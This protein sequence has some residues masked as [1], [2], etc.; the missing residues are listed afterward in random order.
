MFATIELPEFSLQSI[1]RH[2]SAAEDSSPAVLVDTSG[3]KPLVKQRNQAARAAAIEID[4]SLSQAQARAPQVRFF[5]PSQ[6]AEANASKLLFNLAYAHSPFLEETLPGLWTLDLKGLPGKLQAPTAQTLRQELAAHGLHARIGLAPTPDTALFAARAAPPPDFCLLAQDLAAFRRRNLIHIACPSGKLAHILHQ[7][8]IHTLE[9]LVALPRPAVQ[10]RLGAEGGQIWDQ[11]AGKTTRVLRIQHPPH[12]FEEKIELEYAI[13]NLE[14]L[15]FILRRFLDSLSLQ[16]QTCG[17]AAQALK[18][19]LQQED[20][21]TA[22]YCQRFEL[23]EPTQNADRLFRMLHLHLGQ[24]Q[25]EHAL[26]GVQIELEPVNPPHRQEGLFHTSLRDPWRFHE[27]LTQ[28]TGLLG[29]GHM[30]SPRTVA[31]HKPGSFE[32]VPLPDNIPPLPVNSDAPGPA[33]PLRRFRPPIP[34][35]V[36]VD[37]Q[38][39][40]FLR[41]PIAKGYIRETRGPW[42]Y[43]G[44]W[45]ESAQ[46]WSQEEW[47]VALDNGGLYRLSHTPDQ[48]WHLE[49]VY[50]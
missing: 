19:E 38:T 42:R 26:I 37:G 36:R 3:R 15:L 10:R 41:S 39:P 30:G 48:Q 4:M 44:H 2:E 7:W 13:N 50:D 6:T 23:P 31:G 49:G 27:T 17:K 33:A 43:S 8:G 28:L 29:S 18:L 40:G 25:L 21:L 9:Q 22:P 14:A 45:W 12:R 11:A 1:L 34:A 32:L 5:R 20:E 16:L 24:L 47:D 35:D 46:S